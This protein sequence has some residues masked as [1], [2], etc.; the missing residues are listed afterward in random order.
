MDVS[1]LYLSGTK[2]EWLPRT[3]FFTANGTTRTLLYHLVGGISRRFAFFVSP[4]PNPTTEVEV[5][6]SRLQEAIRKDTERLC[7][8]LTARFHVA[9]HPARCSFVTQMVTVTNAVAILRRSNV[10]CTCPVPVWPPAIR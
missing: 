2:G 6:F 9:L 10:T 4:F 7:A 8:V 1:P 3:M 5:T